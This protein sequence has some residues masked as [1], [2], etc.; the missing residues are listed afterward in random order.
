[1]FNFCPFCGF[2]IDQQTKNGFQCPNCKKWTHYASNPAVSI[3]VKVRNEGLIAVRGRDPG[4]G[5]HDLVGGF[6]EFGED[7]LDGAVREFKEETGINIDK[8]KLK[9][10]GMWVDTYLYQE[11]TQLILNIVYLIE[12]PE[13]VVGRPADDVEDLIWVK[14]EDRPSFAFSY[15]YQVWGKLKF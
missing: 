1:M 14:L 6:L 5:M 8:N 9:F 7:P 13:K 15:L 11:N 3:A 10:L 4:K 12:L 2:K